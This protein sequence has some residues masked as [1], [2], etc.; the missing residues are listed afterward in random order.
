VLEADSPDV[1]AKLL[2]GHP[3]LHAPGAVIEVLEHL[4][5]PGM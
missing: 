2:D 4:P 3:H 1:A 5:M